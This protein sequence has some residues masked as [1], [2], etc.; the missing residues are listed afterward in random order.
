MMGWLGLDIPSLWKQLENWTKYMKQLFS[1]VG[2]QVGQ[3]DDASGKRNKGGKPYL[4]PG[5]LFGQWFREEILSR[6]GTQFK[7]RKKEKRPKNR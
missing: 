4:V 6:D 5:A 3:D 2:Q 1:V 7:R